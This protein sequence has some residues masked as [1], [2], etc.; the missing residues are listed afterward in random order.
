MRT[1][2]VAFTAFSRTAA[3]VLAHES[4]AAASRVRV[5]AAAADPEAIS[6]G[7][8][9]NRLDVLQQGFI[10]NVLEALDFKHRIVFFR[11]F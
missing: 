2:M 6:V 4:A 11:F 10:D 3:A 7:V 5:D 9:C 1:Y 8:H